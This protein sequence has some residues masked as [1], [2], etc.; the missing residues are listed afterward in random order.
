MTDDFY[1]SDLILL[2]L[3]KNKVKPPF[4]IFRK[5]DC[6]RVLNGKPFKMITQNQLIEHSSNIVFTFYI[7]YS[8]L[9]ARGK[10]FHTGMLF[11]LNFNN[12]N[13]NTSKY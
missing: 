10:H 13:T 9:G 1:E 2:C 4:K 8:L 11:G 5:K 12:I 7:T 6:L 3:N